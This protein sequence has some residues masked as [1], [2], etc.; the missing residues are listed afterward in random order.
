M[1]G[2]AN[3][4]T[5]ISASG[6]TID[7]TSTLEIVVPDASGMPDS[8]RLISTTGGVTIPDAVLNAA[9]ASVSTQS[10]GKLRLV[11]V[12][13]GKAIDLKVVKGMVISF[14]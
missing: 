8:Q 4:V 14:K 11:K 3:D 9:K 13:G 1:G 10:N 2:Y 5:P 6:V 12:D 7:G